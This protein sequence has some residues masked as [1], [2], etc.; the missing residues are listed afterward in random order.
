MFFPGCSGCRPPSLPGV[1]SVYHS[2]SIP[3]LDLSPL[4]PPP[5][6]RIVKRAHAVLQT[7]RR[8]KE[9]SVVRGAM[10][11][12]VK[13]VEGCTF[14]PE[15]TECPAYI[16]VSKGPKITNERTGENWMYVLL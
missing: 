13:E 4:L 9:E 16:T 2:V 1:P 7:L 15:T 12:A 6:P 8:R 14:R 5:L 11:R 10:E 3:E